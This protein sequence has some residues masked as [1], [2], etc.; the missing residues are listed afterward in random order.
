M[1]L[2]K[3]FLPIVIILVVVLLLGLG[4]GY[5]WFSNQ[6]PQDP[7]LLIGLWRTESSIFPDGEYLEIKEK[8][9]CFTWQTF[10]TEP[11][12]VCSKYAPYIVSGNLIGF[13]ESSQPNTKW[14]ITGNIL[15]LWQ[16]GEKKVYEHVSFSGNVVPKQTSPPQ[17]P[18]PSSPTKQA[19]ALTP[20]TP[21]SAPK[22]PDTEKPKITLFKASSQSVK[23]GGEIIFTCSAI[24]NSGS[25][26]IAFDIAGIIAGGTA[27]ASEVG[28]FRSNGNPFTYTYKPAIAGSYTVTCQ[29]SDE[30]Q[31]KTETFLTFSVSQ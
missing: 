14:E 21:T 8:E 25:V 7:Q 3:G 9:F 18:N 29:V 5:F 10:Q 28:P 17:T 23:A 30:A 12:F 27:N 11:R 31:N 22:L 19:P 20:A 13:G 2:Q 16:S 15:T 6:K 1:N 4:A 24:D 26:Q